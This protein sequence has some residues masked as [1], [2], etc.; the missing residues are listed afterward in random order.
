[1]HVNCR[2]ACYIV[3][4][5]FVKLPW[6]V[7]RY[8]EATITHIGSVTPG[9]RN[10]KAFKLVQFQT[11]QLKSPGKMWIPNQQEKRLYLTLGDVFFNEQ[12]I[13]RI[14]YTPSVKG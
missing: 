14:Y 11:F 1:M 12:Y 6:V 9:K 2:T 3:S 7:P 8:E 4:R 13:H 10:T 5:T